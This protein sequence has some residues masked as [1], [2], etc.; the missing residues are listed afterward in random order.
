MLN[1]LSAHT[2]CSCCAIP[3][4]IT[5]GMEAD[6]SATAAQVFPGL[7]LS[8]FTADVDLLDDAPDASYPVIDSIRQTGYINSEQF[9]TI[10]LDLFVVT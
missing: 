1:T 4:D 7:P 5:S 8:A 9:L 3:A 10:S 2:V 6:L